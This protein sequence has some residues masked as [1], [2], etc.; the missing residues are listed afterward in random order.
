MNADDEDERPRREWTDEQFETL[1]DFL[2]DYVD[3]VAGRLSSHATAQRA[4][5]RRMYCD[6]GV[7]WLDVMSMIVP[8]PKPERGLSQP[9]D[10]LVTR[11]T[12]TQEPP[13]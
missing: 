11:A 7:D 13:Q 8:T 3:V 1:C 5:L 2:S 10:P 12:P 6:I 4:L 9:P